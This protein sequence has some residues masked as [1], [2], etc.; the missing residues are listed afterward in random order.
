M[1]KKLIF[2]VNHGA[3]FVSHRLVLAEEAIRRGWNVKLIIG[4]AGSSE[5]EVPAIKKLDSAGI[6]YKRLSF[7]TIGMNPLKELWGI[8][9]LI[10]VLL[11]EKPDIVHTVSPKG[12]LYGGL[13][14]RITGVNSLVVAISGMGYLYTNTGNILKRVFV[15]C[16]NKVTSFIFSHPNKVVIVQNLN[17]QQQ[18][19]GYESVEAS[20]VYLIP[21]SGVQI[22]NFQNINTKGKGVVLFPARLL[23]DKGVLEFVDAAR[24]LKAKGHKW[25]FV[26][27]GSANYANPS[28]VSKI[29]V[30]AWVK[31]GIVEWYGHVHDMIPLYA[32]SDIVCLP[33]YREGMP[34]VLLEAAASGKAVV[35]TDVIGC[36]EAIIDQQTGI[37][38]PVKNVD[39]LVEAL[40][41]LILD[42]EKRVRFGNKGRELAKQKFSIESVIETTFAIYN[43]TKRIKA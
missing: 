4:Q 13:A 37:L 26:L 17:D 6:E 2:V 31:E 36:R 30:D 11:K 24:A 40:E 9:Q 21:G 29:V 18:I 23:R 22:E 33:S 12:M 38:V 15:K 41:T 27:A 34:K 8:F 19:L 39:K 42:K 3:F 43:R 16:I 35:T 1:K 14:A 20:D 25:R 28:A 32:E 10:F 7:T 5:M